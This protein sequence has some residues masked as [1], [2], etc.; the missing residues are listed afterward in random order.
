MKKEN[1]MILKSIIIITITLIQLNKELIPVVQVM[2][3]CH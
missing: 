3:V 1:L 2:E